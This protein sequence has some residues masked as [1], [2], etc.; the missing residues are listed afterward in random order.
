[1]LEGEE[2]GTILRV[3]KAPLPHPLD[4]RAKPATGLP[5]GQRADFVWPRKSPAWLRV[6]DM[7]DVYEAELTNRAP[8]QPSTPEHAGNDDL[9]NLAA[10][11]AGGAALGAVLGG[12]LGRNRNSLL[13]GAGLGALFGALAGAALDEEPEFLVAH[14]QGEPANRNKKQ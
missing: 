7:G 14:R 1:M 2:P 13:V 10:G 5:V 3:R 9:G 12:V 8:T 4:A 11:A 6:R